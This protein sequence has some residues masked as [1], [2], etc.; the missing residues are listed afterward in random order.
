MKSCIK[1]N[2]LKEAS[3]QALADVSGGCAAWLRAFQIGDPSSP[4]A[5]APHRRRQRRV[6]AAS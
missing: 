1:A 6:S 3:D 2:A 5:Q 4:R